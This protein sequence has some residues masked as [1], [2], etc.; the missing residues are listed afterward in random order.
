MISRK[1]LQEVFDN[2]PAL[3]IVKLGVNSD[4]AISMADNCIIDVEFDTVFDVD[5]NERV[6]WIYVSK[7]G[8]IELASYRLA[9]VDSVTPV[10]LKVLEKLSPK[11]LG[12]D[13]KWEAM[14]A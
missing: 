10:R 3:L 8:D 5:G 13:W 12:G 6:I 9:F 7:P 1:I 2:L 14:A 11:R 4:T